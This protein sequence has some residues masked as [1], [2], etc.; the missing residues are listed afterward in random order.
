MN[1]VGERLL[2]WLAKQQVDVFRHHH[3]SVHAHLKAPPHLLQ[4]AGK[5]S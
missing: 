4:A 1:G 2:L 5:S 3:V